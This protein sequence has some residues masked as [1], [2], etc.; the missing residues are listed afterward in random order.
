[1][2]VPQMKPFENH[3]L[4]SVSIPNLCDSKIVIYFLFSSDIFISLYL[5]SFW[6]HLHIYCNSH[7]ANH[8]DVS[9]LICIF[10]CKYGTRIQ[11]W[12]KPKFL[13]NH[14]TKFLNLVLIAFGYNL[15]NL[16]KALITHLKPNFFSACFPLT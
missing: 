8:S 13:K 5:T 14:D 1:M 15:S 6:Q 9:F 3:E 4:F 10:L 2:S 7:P 11:K 16:L 12:T